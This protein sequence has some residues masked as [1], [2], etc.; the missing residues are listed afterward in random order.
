VRSVEDKLFERWCR[1]ADAGALGR[2]FDRVAP[3]LLALGIHLVGEASEAE[4]LVQTTFLAAIEQRASLDASLPAMPWLTSVLAH[5]AK[6]ARKRA[7]RRIDPERLAERSA[8]DPARPLEQRELSGELARAIDQLGEPYR[9]VLVL[10]LRHGL[11]IADVAHVLE[12]SPG[13]VRVQLHRALEKLRPLLPASLATG[14]VPHAARPRGLA[15]VKAIV[16]REAARSGAAL[17]SS[18][19]VGG[20]IVSQKIVLGA[21]AS[22]ALIALAVWQYESTPPVQIETVDLETPPVHDRAQTDARRVEEPLSSERTN[23][24]EDSSGRSWV[25]G[26]VIDAENQQPIAGA[27][28]QL[29]EP[30]RISLFE[31]ARRHPELYL[32]LANG[33]IRARTRADWPYIGE[34]SAL[35]RFGRDVVST[36][37]GLEADAKPLATVLSDSGGHFAL[38]ADPAGGVL[39][40]AKDGYGQR[41]RAAR[42]TSREWTVALRRE[43][44]MTGHVVTAAG[45]S[46]GESLQLAFTA[47]QRHPPPPIEGQ[48]R[49]CSDEETEALGSWM[50]SCDESGSFTVL[51]AAD[52]VDANVL[53]PGWTVE[54]F[55]RYPD[56]P[57]EIVV[58]R[59]PVL[60]FFDAVTRA[61]VER[62]RLIGRESTDRLVRW[63]GEFEAPGGLLV[64]PGDASIFKWL[65][66]D[67]FAFSAWADGYGVASFQVS[68]VDRGALVE[69]PLERGDLCS[70]EGFV[71]RGD[72]PCGGAEAALSTFGWHDDDNL[73]DAI[74]ADR[75]GA[76]RLEA[77]RGQYLLRIVHE[78]TTY[79]EPVELPSSATID[80][81]LA[82]TGRIEVEVVDALGVPRTDHVVVLRW[83]DRRDE[84]LTTDEHGLAS[85]A[86]L[87]SGHFMVMT[88]HVTTETSFRADEFEELELDRGETRQVRLEIP[89]LTAPRHARI[90]ARGVSLYSDWRVHYAYTAPDWEALE[91]DGTVPMDLATP[92]T[93]MDV[94]APDGR[95][96]RVA[97]PRDA[98]DGYEI[99]LDGGTGSYRGVLLDAAGNPKVGTRIYLDR[100]ECE[101]GMDLCPSTVTDAVGRFEFTGLEACV[102]RFEFREGGARTSETFD[103]TLGPITFVPSRAAFEDPWLEIHLA[104]ELGEKHVRGIVRRGQ[105]GAPLS[106]AYVVFE[107][108]M[109]SDSGKL[110]VRGDHGSTRTDVEGRFE[111]S[112]P[113]TP[114]YTVKV[115]ETWTS[116]GLVLTQVF[117]DS[118]LD[119]DPALELIVPQ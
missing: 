56:G 86:P 110:L 112:C 77:A 19:I 39:A 42:D 68:Q 61:P 95:R 102:Y 83:A 72:H 27:T 10:R 7:A 89:C 5:K 100:W 14:L 111:I 25:R 11:P 115:Y 35:A 94:L 50:T 108:E 2:L 21:V 119:E 88:P 18:T 75:T 26:V 49:A 70:L 51:V 67:S 62:V 54:R 64:L 32:V 103:G 59:A 78:D 63:S 29:F 52:E 31:A 57:L 45:Q 107:C 117:Q 91:S 69:V 58:R 73:I 43:V 4:D 81:D 8:E 116:D 48:P 33:R 1:H 36:Y 105:D 114:I 90:V 17:G 24:A 104:P 85:F 13:T 109:S 92:A 106:E 38:P 9:Q 71:H 55:Q 6:D 84:R 41:I 37:G 22:I 44:E 76:F 118:G 34:I 40:C 12:R 30:Q 60:H 98:L 3:R 74:R 15:A 23:L 47:V 66:K 99:H 82:R 80:I 46:P 16:L 53:T 97:I 65:E 20:W 79:F 93:H 87:P 113:R 28:V 96:W 101:E